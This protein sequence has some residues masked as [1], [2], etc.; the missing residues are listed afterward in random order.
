MVARCHTSRKE[1]NPPHYL[2]KLLF[3]NMTFLPNLLH[4]FNHHR[5]K[6][7]SGFGF[8]QIRLFLIPLLATKISNLKAVIQESESELES[9]GEEDPIP[10]R[11]LALDEQ[12]VSEFTSPG[13]SPGQ[14]SSLLASTPGRDPSTV[15]T[16]SCLSDVQS[17]TSTSTT[18]KVEC[19]LCF[20]SFPIDEVEHHA[21]GCAA[22]FVLI[23]ANEK[24]GSSVSYKE[25]STTELTNIFE[26]SARDM[27]TLVECITN[28]KDFG[29]KTEMEVVRVTVRR[30]MVWEDFKRSMRRYYQPDRLLKITFAGETAVDDGG[31]KREFFAGRLLFTFT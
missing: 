7:V 5:Y 22:S 14:C 4:I 6:E 3:S 25:N 31:P 26:E 15:S 21:D 12:A 19:P 30:K 27:V 24:E 13:A 16:S 10:P 28:L 20:E 9:S 2:A 23:E 17:I 11:V 1:R 8:S 18:M 29:L